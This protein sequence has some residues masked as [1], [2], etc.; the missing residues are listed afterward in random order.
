[1]SALCQH[2]FRYGPQLGMTAQMRHARMHIAG[3]SFHD[4]KFG[5]IVAASPRAMLTV[6]RTHFVDTAGSEVDN[7]AGVTLLNASKAAMADITFQGLGFDVVPLQKNTTFFTDAPRKLSVPPEAEG[8][9]LPLDQ[10]SDGFLLADNADFQ[11]LQQVCSTCMHVA[12]PH[13]HLTCRMATR[14]KI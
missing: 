3:C 8:S 2:E 5:G 11:A 13:V 10:R 14:F 6:Q 7:D 12:S 4:M 9:L 1:M